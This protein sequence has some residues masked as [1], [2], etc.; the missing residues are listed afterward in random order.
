[1]SSNSKHKAECKTAAGQTSKRE[2]SGEA[3]KQFWVAAESKTKKRRKKPLTREESKRRKQVK[4]AKKNRKKVVEVLNDKKPY[5]RLLRDSSLRELLTTSD[6]FDLLNGEK[7]TE[8][9]T[10]VE[11]R[12]SLQLHNS[13]ET[14]HVQRL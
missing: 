4:Q 11:E 13:Q 12:S 1:M 3:W 7:P 5:S 2:G 10:R 8:W 9:F 6:W 14:F